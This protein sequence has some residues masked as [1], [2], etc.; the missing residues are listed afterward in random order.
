MYQHVREAQRDDITKRSLHY[1]ILSILEKGDQIAYQKTEC[2]TEAEAFD[3]EKRLIALYGRKDLGM[4]PLCNLT[5]GGEGAKQSPESIE[6]RAAKHRGMKRSPEARERMRKAQLDKA[7]T[8]RALYGKGCSPEQSALY[9][10]FV[11][12]F[13]ITKDVEAGW[14][15]INL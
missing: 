8:S 3:E 4:G 14:R 12:L 13:T 7:A 15:N 9:V 6:K 10:E 1:K 5:D 11:E 2:A